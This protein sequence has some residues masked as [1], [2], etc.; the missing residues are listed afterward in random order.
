MKDSLLAK[1]KIINEVTIPI[2]W[3]LIQRNKKSTA[4]IMLEPA[5]SIVVPK[6]KQTVL[7]TGSVMFD[8]EVAYKK[9]KPLNYYLKNAGGVNDK[10]WARKVYVVNANGSASS[11]SSFLMFKSYPKV[12]PGSKIIVPEKPERKGN[13]TGEIVGIAS[14]LASLTGVLLAVFR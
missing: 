12:Q 3:K 10:G 1:R 14:V 13:T 6:K 9:G 8:T 2:D 4:N 11:S 5:D 7:I